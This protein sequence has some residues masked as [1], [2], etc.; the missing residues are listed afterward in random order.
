MPKFMSSLCFSS[1]IALFLWEEGDSGNLMEA[2]EIDMYV[3]LKIASRNNVVPLDGEQNSID[4]NSD[5]GILAWSTFVLPHGYYQVLFIP[6][7]R[8]KFFGLCLTLV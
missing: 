4:K 2:N 6:W 3:G 7:L 1:S 8:V 5:S